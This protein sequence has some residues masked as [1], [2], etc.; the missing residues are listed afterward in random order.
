M[1]V[2]FLTPARHDLLRAVEYYQSEEAASA[3]AAFL[4]EVDEAR[5]LI[6]DFP[7]L[8]AP[9][10]KGTRRVQ[11]HSFPYSLIYR[12]DEDIVR[13]FAVQH[14]SMEPRSWEARL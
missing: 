13:V 10:P 6:S 12:I 5:D 2:R 14:H 7:R 11:L 9:A 8:G 4:N 1:Q 3:A